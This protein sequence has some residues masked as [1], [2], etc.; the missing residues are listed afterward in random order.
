MVGY[1]NTRR[2]S[3]H[4]AHKGIMIHNP[5][6]TTKH[7]FVTGK[8]F[9][10]TQAYYAGVSAPCECSYCGTPYGF[11]WTRDECNPRTIEDP[12]HGLS[13]E[14]YVFYT[15]W[16]NCVWDNDEGAWW[17]RTTQEYQKPKEMMEYFAT[18]KQ[19]D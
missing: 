18:V 12:L 8:P 2:N 7:N 10:Q 1:S 11:E 9:S 17:S 19:I 5:I 16:K 4:K 14:A 15:K 6:I 3:I 13:E